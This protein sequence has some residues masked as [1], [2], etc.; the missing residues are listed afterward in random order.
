[1]TTNDATIELTQETNLKPVKVHILLDRSG[2][3]RGFETDV[4]GG[5][6]SFLEKQRKVKG[7]CALTLVQFDDEDPFEMIYNDLDL[8][9]VPNLTNDKYWPRGLTPLWDAVGRLVTSADKSNADPDVDN[10]VWIFTDGMENASREYDSKA[11]KSL[12]EEKTE[13]GW[14]I[15]YLGADHDAILQS[16]RFGFQYEKS[17]H[18]AKEDSRDEF[19]YVT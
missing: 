16:R 19:K 18:Y 6:N 14:L 11:I 15:I 13:Q 2:S 4:I 3:M 9:S 12:I 10:I 1:M 17:L 7:D 5:F 8:G